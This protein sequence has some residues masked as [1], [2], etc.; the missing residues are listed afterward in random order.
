MDLPT[1]QDVE[2]AAKRLA[3]VIH[4]TPVLTCRTLDEMCG[5]RLFLKCENFQKGGAFKIR[6]AT[7]AVL[8]LSDDQAARGVVTHSSGNHGAAL[9]LAARARGIRAFVVMPRN[10]PEIKKKAVAG[11]GAE[12]VECAPTL[13]ARERVGAEVM[14]RTSAALVHSYDDNRIIAG[15]GTAALE[16]CE[17]VGHL[18]AVLA[19]V[20]GGGLLSGTALA[21]AHVSPAARVIAV[22]PEG[23]D[24]AYRSFRAGRLIPA[25]NPQTIADGLRTSLSERTFAILRRHVAD[26][27]TVSEEAIVHAMRTIW[28]RMKIVVEPSGAVPLA[29]LLSGRLALPG[30]RVGILLS[31]GNVDLDRLPWH[32][33]AH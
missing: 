6:G 21:V 15:Q 17:D 18:D 8:T 4:R 10:A 29:A 33:E 30:K 19:P 7:N 27:V 26:V 22:E 2:A 1:F 31:G 20:G 14:A 3:P 32:L 25:E 16:L 23:A 13:A 12:I 9:A 11:Y 24:D 5:A 28:E